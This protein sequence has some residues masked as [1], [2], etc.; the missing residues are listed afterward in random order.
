M[1][2]ATI[3]RIEKTISETGTITDDRKNELLQLVGNLKEEINNLEEAHQEHAGSIMSYAESSV[4]EATRMQPDND[5]LKHSL[6]G[7]SL[8]VRRFE[9]SHPTL[10]GVINN[11]GQVLGNIGI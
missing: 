3:K 9:V 1:I 11:I 4:R 10:I 8:S 2:D 5:L 6:D 7:L